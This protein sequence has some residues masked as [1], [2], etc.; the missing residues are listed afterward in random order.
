MDKVSKDVF[1]EVV[2]GNIPGIKTAAGKMPRKKQPK[3]LE[4]RSLEA[5]GEFVKVVCERVSG[6]YSSLNG[7]NNNNK[8]RGVVPEVEEALIVVTPYCTNRVSG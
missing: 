6:R 4:T 3:T 5:V 2:S 1:A 8:M 7:D